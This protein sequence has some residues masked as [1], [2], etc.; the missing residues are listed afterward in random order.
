VLPGVSQV[1]P[2]RTRFASC[3]GPGQSKRWG[4]FRSA[5]GDDIERATGVC[6]P[7]ESQQVQQQQ[8]QQQQQV[9][10]QVDDGTDTTQLPAAA[11]DGGKRRRL[12][13]PDNTVQ[14]DSDS[15]SGSGSGSSSS[16]AENSEPAALQH[17]WR[18]C[19]PDSKG[20]SA[21][22][23]TEMR[24]ARRYCPAEALGLL[25]LGAC[26]LCRGEE[27]VLIAP[28]T[29][30]PIGGHS[31]THQPT[32]AMGDADGTTTPDSKTKAAAGNGGRTVVM[33][34]CPRGYVGAVNVTCTAMG[35]SGVLSGECL[36]L[37]D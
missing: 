25:R 31:T 21:Y 19:A 9:Q 24:C 7:L 3:Y 32:A 22:S 14:S 1:P 23:G 8:Q 33:L 27:P 6:I 11:G 4:L 10:Q 29:L 18:H 12:S 30:V 28:R 35:W 16:S 17:R 34:S 15:G 5:Y 13:G 26:R 20:G 37:S 36:R 2:H